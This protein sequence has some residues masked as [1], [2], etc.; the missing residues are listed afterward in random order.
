MNKILVVYHLPNASVNHPQHGIPDY[1]HKPYS[2][3]VYI[4]LL[5]EDNS[6]PV[7][8]RLEGVIPQ[9]CLDGVNDPVPVPPAQVSIPRCFHQPSL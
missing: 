1:L 3:E 7:A 2:P 6:L 8:L 4:P 5:Q 9:G